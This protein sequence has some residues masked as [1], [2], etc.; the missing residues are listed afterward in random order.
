MY[1][2]NERGEFFSAA[3]TEFLQVN[4]NEEELDDY[5]VVA[6]RDSYETRQPMLQ[7]ILSIGYFNWGGGGIF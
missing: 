1:C 2:E 3:K 4:D 7:D 5:Y 6:A